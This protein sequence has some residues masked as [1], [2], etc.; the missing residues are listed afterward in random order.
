MDSLK[1]EE[2]LFSLPV[3]KKGLKT[4]NDG[5]AI[6]LVLNWV[7]FLFSAFNQTFRRHLMPVEMLFSRIFV[8]PVT[9]SIVKICTWTKKIQ[10]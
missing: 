2:K 9:F 8:L 6:F 4:K 7:I 5:I 1:N 10:K 3:M